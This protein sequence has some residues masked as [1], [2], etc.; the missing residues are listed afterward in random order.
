MCNNGE[1]CINESIISTPVNHYSL[2]AVKL[3]SY[4]MVAR[5]LVVVRVWPN[6]VE[7]YEYQPITANNRINE[8]AVI[9]PNS[10]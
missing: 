2:T 1:L 5:K 10:Y 3:L 8:I 7:Y 6:R 4:K 9:S